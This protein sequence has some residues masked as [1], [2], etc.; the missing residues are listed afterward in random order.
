MDLDKFKSIREEMDQM[1]IEF[2][3]AFG[4]SDV[5]IKSIEDELWHIHNQISSVNNNLNDYKRINSQDLSKTL[6]N[7]TFLEKMHEA[8]K[9][10]RKEISTVY[11]SKR[12][13]TQIFKRKNNFD[14]IKESD[15]EATEK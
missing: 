11:I 8:M 5:K 10:F 14:F 3:A 4:N 1:K 13:A 15:E 12:E 2:L 9:E 7:E 6:S